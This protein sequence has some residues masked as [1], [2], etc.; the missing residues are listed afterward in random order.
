M[1]ISGR[2]QDWKSVD[3]ADTHRHGNGRYGHW[4][5][6]QAQVVEGRERMGHTVM[7]EELEVTDDVLQSESSTIFDQA[8][9]RLHTIEATLVAAPT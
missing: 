4:R 7:P 1:A 3:L 2:E 9:N 6:A 8:E 5:R